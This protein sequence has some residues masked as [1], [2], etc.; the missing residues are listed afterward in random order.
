MTWS[1]CDHHPGKA[2]MTSELRPDHGFAVTSSD[3]N[4]DHNN[5]DHS[6]VIF[7]NEWVVYYDTYLLYPGEYPSY[8]SLNNPNM[9]PNFNPNLI[10]DNILRSDWTLPSS[11]IFYKSDLPFATMM[12]T[13]QKS[14]PNSKI[15]NTK[16]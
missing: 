4:S 10:H 3:R 11:E 16:Y 14:A 1:L 15:D 9:I 12:D 6:I 5:D 2:W 7:N 8:S 13:P